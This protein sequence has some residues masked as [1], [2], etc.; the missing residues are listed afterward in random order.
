VERLVE[1][2][3]GETVD[4][5]EVG[6]KGLFFDGRLQLEGSV[7]YYDY[8]NF[9]ITFFEKVGVG[10]QFTTVNGGEATGYGTELAANSQPWEWL[11]FFTNFAWTHA[12]FDSDVFITHRRRR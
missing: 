12:R 11:N 1:I 10:G 7:Y 8:Q 6:G 4:S 2:I 5:Y 3:P 9:Q